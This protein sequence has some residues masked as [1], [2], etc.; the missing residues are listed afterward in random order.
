MGTDIDPQDSTTLED[1]IDSAPPRPELSPLKKLVLGLIP[2]ILLLFVAEII[3]RVDRGTLL[4]LENHRL[5]RLER[6][7]R[8]YPAMNDPHLGYVPIPSYSSRDNLWQKQVT[9]DEHGFRSN[10]PGIRPE[11]RLIVAVG[12]SFT[13]GDQVNDAETWP[14]LLEKNFGRPVINGGV[15]GYSFG[16]V[17]LRAEEI[18]DQQPTDWLVVS[19]IP[20]D[21]KRCEN[22]KWYAWKPYFDLKGQ[23]LVVHYP[24]DGSVPVDPAE[25]R[26]MQFK[27]GLGYSALVD[28]V[29]S[30]TPARSWWFENEV[31]IRAHPPGTGLEIAKRLVNR[32][33]AHAEKEG[34]HLLLVSQGHTADEDAAALLEHAQD[35]G[36]ATLDLLSTYLAKEAKD[37]G[38]RDR[39]FQGHMTAEGNQW[40]ADQLLDY[41]R[42]IESQSR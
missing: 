21:I 26:L 3:A 6:A 25:A 22:K 19:F 14:A 28:S 33:A 8:G 40:V 24:P 37:P 30:H 31:A 7:R 27:N 23:G 11:G 32:I 36:V 12:D 4:R 9:I 15:F 5:M 29:L 13:F 2:L 35:T 41:I 16:Q 39:Y 1:S 42:K 10:G 34:Y 20:S 38:L 18:L 17:I